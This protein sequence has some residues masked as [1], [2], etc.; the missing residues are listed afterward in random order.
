MMAARDDA[1]IRM[2]GNPEQGPHGHP[3]HN[4]DGTS[5]TQVLQTMRNLIVE[6]QVFKVDNE[7]LKK[8]Q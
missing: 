3:R 7:K 4:S 6:L 2:E 5:P 1:A 8:S